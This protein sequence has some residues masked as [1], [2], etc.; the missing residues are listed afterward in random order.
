MLKSSRKIRDQKGAAVTGL[1]IALMFFILMAGFFCFDA[2]RVQMAQRALTAT[3]DA[4]ALAG[5][6]MLTSYD[7]SNDTGPPASPVPA[8]QKLLDAQNNSGAYAYNMFLMGNIL[9]RWVRNQTNLV[10]NLAG[11]TTTT[12]GECNVCIGLVNPQ[13]NFATVPPTIPQNANGTAIGVYAGYGYHPIFISFFGVGNIGIRASSVGGL[14]QVDAVVVLDLSGSMD[15]LTAVTLVKRYWDAHRG[16]GSNERPTAQGYAGSNPDTLGWSDGPNEAYQAV[17]QMLGTNAYDATTILTADLGSQPSGFPSMVGP[18]FT[19][20]KNGSPDGSPDFDEFSG[21]GCITYL[22]APHWS[23]DTSLYQYIHLNT[24]VSLTG[25]SLNAL[26]PQNLGFSERGVAATQ[27]KDTLVFKR[28]LRHSPDRNDF[29]SPPGNCPCVVSSGGSFSPVNSYGWS[30]SGGR[31]SPYKNYETDHWHYPLPPCSFQSNT[32][33]QAIID[34]SAIYTDLV[35][36]FGQPT[37]QVK[38]IQPAWGQ[39][40]FSEV[41]YQ[42]SS[43]ASVEEDPDIRGQSYT[44]DNIAVLCEAA[45]GNLDAPGLN[46]TNNFGSTGLH[47]GY[48]L[49]GG[50]SAYQSY[51]AGS[52]TG[53]VT[54]NGTVSPKIAYQKAYQ[55]LAMW[56]CQPIATTLDSCDQA[57]FQRLAALTDCRFGLVGFSDRWTLSGNPVYSVSSSNTGVLG[58]TSGTST[59]PGC[60]SYFYDISYQPIVNGSARAWDGRLGPSDS[61][62]ATLHENRADQSVGGGTG[63]GFRVP[64]FPLSTTISKNEA[65]HCMQ[66]GDP[67][68]S[69]VIAWS[70][71]NHG[72]GLYQGRALSMTQCSEALET[73]RLSFGQAP[74]NGASRAG[75]KRAIVFFTDGVPVPSSEEAPSRITAAD[76]KTDGIAI[77]SI[78]LNMLGSGPLTAQQTAFLGNHSN[79]LS[80]K[81]KNG[82]RAFICNNVLQVQQAFSAIARRLTQSQK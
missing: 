18:S 68:L 47:R 71:P 56:Y 65:L 62:C 4:A 57:F 36:N 7:V 15:D 34:H 29:N 6:A 32:P 59:S 50:K 21:H 48:D 58:G 42:F 14:P 22:E 54:H 27:P 31:T 64:R 30:M 40:I 33:G 10:S 81:A 5:T 75:S 19:S 26:P 49:A 11:L 9:G 44:F 45:R 24:A 2:S 13:N 51:Y 69:T 53:M 63:I 41:S 17:N 37:T 35:V 28:F 23:T 1:V 12:D 16:T 70:D 82:G 43:D 55:R 78:A 73:A 38:P 76:C 66:K 77:F 25:T 52:A 39:Q 61:T 67:T 8:G 80:G 74:Y 60:N 3:C 72:H 46:G 79:G 20:E